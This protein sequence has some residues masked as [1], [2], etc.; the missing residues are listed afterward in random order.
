MIRDYIR[1]KRKEIKIKLE[2]YTAIEM[3]KDQY[4]DIIDLMGRIYNTLKDIPADE[5]KSELIQQIAELMQSETL[6][7]Q[8]TEKNK[9]DIG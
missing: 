1:L 3:V 2:L 4:Q 5:L 8:G 7:E 9:A 6:K